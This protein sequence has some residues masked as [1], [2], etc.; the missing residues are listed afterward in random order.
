[1]KRM[2]ALSSILLFVSDVCAAAVKGANAVPALGA[3]GLLGIAVMVGLLGLRA[4]R[5]R[6]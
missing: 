1:M 2:L 6:R 5:S 3:E 4:L